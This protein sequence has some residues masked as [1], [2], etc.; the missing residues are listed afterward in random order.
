MKLDPLG[1][2]AHIPWPRHT[3]QVHVVWWKPLVSTS[4]FSGPQECPRPQ[5]FISYFQPPRIFRPNRR[6]IPVCSEVQTHG[7]GPT[8]P[9]LR[10]VY[11]THSLEKPFTL[12]FRLGP[13]VGV[14]QETKDRGADGESTIDPRL[15]RLLKE[16]LNWFL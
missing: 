3:S 9:V 7:T 1:G 10:Q 15:P 4:S 13:L 12:N 6:K 8:L 2:H 5:I 11:L 16:W 14:V